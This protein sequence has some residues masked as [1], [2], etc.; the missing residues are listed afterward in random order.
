MFDRIELG[1][2]FFEG[3]MAIDLAIVQQAGA[4]GC[5]F[6]GGRLHRG[7]YPRKPR[8]GLIGRAA[9]SFRMRFSLCCGEEGC[10]RRA[11]PASV[12]FL[13]RR[14]YTAA[15]VIVASVVA[16]MAS[17]ASGGADDGDRGQDGAAMAMVARDVPRDASLRGAIGAVFAG[18]FTTETA[19]I[20][21][22]ETI[23]I[24]RSAGRGA[25]S[26]AVAADDGDVGGEIFEG[27]P[28][29]PRHAVR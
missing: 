23:G 27:P 13:G 14:V 15:V 24:A 16:L 5:R 9:E 4:Q 2:E 1:S 11:T 6:C 19:G 3:L 20:D 8:G 18:A 21:S 26:V 29:R 12:R 10:R 17:T 7:D 28:V 25:S 22:G